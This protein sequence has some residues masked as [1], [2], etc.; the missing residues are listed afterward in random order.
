MPG[1]RFSQYGLWN[2]VSV[3]FS[4]VTWYCSWVSCSRNS[5]SLGTAISSGCVFSTTCLSR[6]WLHQTTPPVR[7]TAKTRPPTRV[8]WEERDDG[9]SILAMRKTETLHW[10]TN[11][12]QCPRA[13]LWL[14]GFV[15]SRLG[16][17][18][19]TAERD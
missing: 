14:L 3:P 12:R 18:D 5:R 10:K 17:A 7:T 15:A 13:T 6:T 2:A 16:D 11:L 4:R 8:T 1:L 19:I 9:C